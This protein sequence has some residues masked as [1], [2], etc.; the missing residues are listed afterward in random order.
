M[1]RADLLAHVVC[2]GSVCG[3][4]GVC[5]PNRVMPVSVSA[6][7]TSSL[8]S[9]CCLSPLQVNS[10][11]ELLFWTCLQPRCKFGMAVYARSVISM[12]RSRSCTPSRPPSP[13]PPP[14]TEHH[15]AHPTQGQWSVDFSRTAPVQHVIPRF[16]CTAREKV[17]VLPVA[18]IPSPPFPGDHQPCQSRGVTQMNWMFDMVNSKC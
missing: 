2:R 11:L 3:A 5:V 9:I 10:T 1:E 8:R 18:G 7:F 16:N 12:G 6:D 4:K 15:A 14:A 17:S 13:P